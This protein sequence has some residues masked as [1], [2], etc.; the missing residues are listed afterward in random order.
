MG[1]GISGAAPIFIMC[2]LIIIYFLCISFMYSSLIGKSL[3]IF[4]VFISGNI[5]LKA[6][7]G[8]D[9]AGLVLYCLAAMVS[10]ILCNRFYYLCITFLNSSL[11]GKSLYIFYIFPSG[12]IW[13]KAV[14]GLDGAGLVLYCLAAMVSL[15]LCNQTDSFAVFEDSLGNRIVITLLTLSRTYLRFLA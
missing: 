5:W 14:Q 13:L 10:L 6:V 7:Q 11:L 8:L 2:G 9:G 4:S 12:N 15:I 3:Y 1:E